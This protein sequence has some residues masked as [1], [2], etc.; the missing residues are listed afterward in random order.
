MALVQA[1]MDRADAV[2]PFVDGGGHVVHG[3]AVQ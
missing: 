3:L 2:E 1:D